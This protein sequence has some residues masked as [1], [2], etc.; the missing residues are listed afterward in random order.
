MSK[1]V[2]L[3]T[4]FLFMKQLN[5]NLT[6]SFKEKDIHLF[7]SEIVLDELKGQNIRG[8]KNDY[9]KIIDRINNSRYSKIYFDI[10]DNTDLEE[11]FVESDKKMDNYYK[12]AFN[13]NIIP[14]FDKMTLFETLME[15]SKHKI[16]PFGDNPND[17]DKG[18]K[19]TMIWINFLEYCKNN[20]FSNYYFVTKDSGFKKNVDF[21]MYEFKEVVGTDNIEILDFS[22]FDEIKKYF[23]IE[24]EPKDSKEQVKAP[25]GKEE[26]TISEEISEEIISKARNSFFD[27]LI[28]E[29]FDSFGN[30]YHSVN[31]VVEGEVSDQDVI[32]FSQLLKRKTD[33]FTFYSSYDLTNVFDELYI[34]VQ[35]KQETEL[36]KIKNFISVWDLIS[37]KYS[38]YLYAYISFIKDEFKKLKS[39]EYPELG[40]EELPF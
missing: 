30:E 26:K 15:R 8:I 19:D 31:L 3:D 38:D 36:S 1:L 7:I 2:F 35:A 14:I 6:S 39:N 32:N 11:A 33:L 22:D 12:L 25:F 40:S 20:S 18:F 13:E 4:N 17:S 5:E 23:E 37:E 16:P 21:F 28:V 34:P 24:N 10:K 29:E 9:N 27:L